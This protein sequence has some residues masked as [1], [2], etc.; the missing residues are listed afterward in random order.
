MLL[1][2]VGNDDFLSFTWYFVLVLFIFFMYLW[3]LWFKLFLDIVAAFIRAAVQVWKPIRFA[4]PTARGGPDYKRL[5]VSIPVSLLEE[6]LNPL[7]P[8]IH[9]IFFFLDDD[10]S[11]FSAKK[12]MDFYLNNT[13]NNLKLLK[14]FLRE[15]NLE[16]SF[17]SNPDRFISRSITQTKLS[18]YIS[19]TSCYFKKNKSSYKKTF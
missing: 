19:C 9:R 13:E 10:V 7:R 12:K 16:T 17:N 2:L 18:K 14:I 15:N 5:I 6:L 3:I 8:L 4:I 11:I 1:K